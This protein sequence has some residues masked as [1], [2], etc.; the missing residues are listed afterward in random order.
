MTKWRQT[1]IE[2]KKK[3]ETYALEDVYRNKKVE[4]K[5]KKE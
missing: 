5:K 2:E 1:E 3:K 4:K